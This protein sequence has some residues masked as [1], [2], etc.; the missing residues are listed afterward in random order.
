MGFHVQ[1]NFSCSICG[2]FFHKK[3]LYEKHMSMAHG[4]SE[5]VKCPECDKC[6][7]VKTNLLA[8]IQL[9]HK[10]EKSYKCFI[11]NLSF[12]QKQ[13]LFSHHKHWHPDQP[14]HFC[15]IC[16]E[17][18]EGVNSLESH[19]CPGAEVN[20]GRIVCHLHDTPKR[21]TSQALLEQHMMTE[22][23]TKSDDLQTSCCICH[24]TFMF[25]KNLNRHLRVVHGECSATSGMFVCTQC[26]KQFQ[27][28]AD[29]ENHILLHQGERK[30]KCSFDLCSKA[31]FSEK[32]LKN[33][34]K[35]HTSESQE[36]LCPICDKLLSTKFKL[37]NHMLVHS[38][39]K[40]FQCSFC[41]KYFKEKKNL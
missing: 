40:Q 13:N 36:E 35:I 12:N 41:Y 4:H 20:S 1:T 26:G 25:K 32:A 34:I 23:G 7:N 37:K 15:K 2:D 9:V 18:F 16:I 5:S 11:C 17:I 10:E 24:K 27:Y 21:F 31:Y 8:H 6:F 30:Y 22:H 19:D 33:H 28:K 14:I 39:V 38:D 29:F 3:W